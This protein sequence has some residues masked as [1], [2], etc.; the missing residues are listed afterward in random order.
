M[1]NHANVVVLLSRVQAVVVFCDIRPELRSL[2]LGA[3]GY[4]PTVK[5]P[6]FILPLCP[7]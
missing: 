2:N 7:S 6:S 3:L 5:S 4:G 1:K